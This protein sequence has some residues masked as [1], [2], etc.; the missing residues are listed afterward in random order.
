MRIICQ[1]NDSIIRLSVNFTWVLTD[2]K[3]DDIVIFFPNVNK[4]NYFF[5]RLQLLVWK[6]E[7]CLFESTNY[8]LITYL[9]PLVRPKNAGTCIKLWVLS[10]WIVTHRFVT[11]YKVWAFYQFRAIF[12]LSIRL[13]WK[14]RIFYNIVYYN[15]NT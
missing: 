4:L 15:S 5:C 10:S 2:K 3:M 6:F 1:F 8:D 13:F 7:H 12:I 14:Y 9:K 11:S